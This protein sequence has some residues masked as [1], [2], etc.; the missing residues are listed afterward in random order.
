MAEKAD[1]AEADDTGPRIYKG[2]VVKL[3]ALDLSNGPVIVQTLPETRKA[4]RL[5]LFMVLER[6]DPYT[7]LTYRD[8]RDNMRRKFA[9]GA[10]DIEV[11]L[12]QG[13]MGEELRA[14]VKAWR[15]AALNE[16]ANWPG[17]SLGADPEMFVV[18]KDGTMVPAFTFLGSK[19]EPD[20]IQPNWVSYKENLYWDGFQ[21]EF[22]VRATGC[23]S[24]VVDSIQYGLAALHKKAKSVNKDY[25]LSIDSVLPVPD[26]SL[27]DAKDEHVE[28]GCAPSYNVY[29]LSGNKRSGREVPIR[30][31]GGH[32]HLGING[33]VGRSGYTPQQLSSGVKALDA[34]LGVACVS[35]FE[36][37]DNPARRQFYGLPGEYRE[38]KH[39]I[40]YRAL[41]NA[42]LVHPLITNAVMDTARRAFG[43]G[44]NM[45][46][47]WDAP[48]DEVVACMRDND[49]GLARKILARN[50]SAFVSIMNVSSY[51]NTS[52]TLFNLF[53]GGMGHRLKEP[54]DVAAN[55]HL[56]EPWQSHCEGWEANWNH[57]RASL[58]AGKSI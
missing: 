43:Y 5:P 29:G 22:T 55:W 33:Y 36:G 12:L 6:N 56:D 16:T 20:V 38:P 17:G 21:A 46:E 32:I 15:R 3:N 9:Y 58:A 28:F 49:V 45:L 2:V 48:E 42:W 44:F 57:A 30:F 54:R 39:G 40:E 41:S 51:M 52:E 27:D 34:I 4:N 18:D 11:N 23:L 50:K 53:Y 31:A 7:G 8:P 13:R 10:K 37:Y 14:E 19:K 26:G 24:Y 35:M 1:E 47:G 25:R